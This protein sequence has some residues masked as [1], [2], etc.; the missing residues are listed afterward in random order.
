MTPSH[1]KRMMDRK[2]HSKVNVPELKPVQSK[3]AVSESKPAKSLH[4]H[5]D[6]IHKS[7]TQMH[8]KQII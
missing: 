6:L 5:Q 7:Q 3:Q 1:K 2:K 4:H 8:I